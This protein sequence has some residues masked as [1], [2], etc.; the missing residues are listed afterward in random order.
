MQ[1]PLWAAQPSTKPVM[2][3]HPRSLCR[4]SSKSWI[5]LRGGDVGQPSWRKK[6]LFWQSKWHNKKGG[7]VGEGSGESG[8][9]RLA[10]QH[11]Q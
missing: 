4:C 10:W 6:L 1:P 5:H 8:H 7:L 9:V 3:H 2:H 11:E